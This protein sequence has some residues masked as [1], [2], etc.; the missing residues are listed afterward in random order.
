[1]IKTTPKIQTT[2]R[3]DDFQIQHKDIK[4]TQQNIQENQI[5]EKEFVEIESSLDKS[6]SHY[7]NEKDSWVIKQG[8]LNKVEFIKQFQ[9]DDALLCI[10]CRLLMMNTPHSIKS[11]GDISS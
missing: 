1:M 6:Q 3:G 8:T 5:Q 2:T 10:Y 11:M 4:Y 9:I 7:D